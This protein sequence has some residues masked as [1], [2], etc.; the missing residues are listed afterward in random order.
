MTSRSRA[1]VLIGLSVVAVLGF[2]IAN[3]SGKSTNSSSTSSATSTSRSASN[4]GST[5]TTSRPA[6]Q[7][8]FTVVVKGAKPVGGVQKITVK[9][10]DR[11]DL[12]VE[13]DVA[14]EIHIHGYD[15]HKSVNAGGAVRFSFPAT[16]DGGFEIELESRKQKIADLT[17][18]P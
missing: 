6:G 15:F 8:A 10:G 13:S 16:I 11:V 2:V 17:V 7:K 4:T 9:K 18:N 1:A 12:V 5:S 3:G 14:D